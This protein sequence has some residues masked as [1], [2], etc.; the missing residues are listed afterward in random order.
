MMW[1]WALF[2]ILL[3]I[4]AAGGF[5]TVFGMAVVNGAVNL[6]VEFPYISTCGAY[7][8]QSCLFS[9]VMNIGA[10]LVTWVCVIRYQ[11]IRDLGCHSH[12]NTV[13][14]VTGCLSAL[15]ATLVGNFQTIAEI[16]VH[17]A[18]A[19]LSF[20]IG[21][22]YFWLQVGL[23]YQVKPRHGGKWCGPVRIICCLACTASLASMLWLHVSGMRSAAAIC[24]WVAGMVLLLL[25]GLFAVDFRHV[26]GH[27]FHVQRNPVVIQNSTTTL[28]L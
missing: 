4:T 14:L 24:E 19:F 17:L 16:H 20:F 26:D 5:W 28:E 8:P 9:Q 15:G 10:F 18:G 27:Y 2:P 1:A 23:T 11:Q 7:P 21:T 3:M 6:T 12:L 25:F 22:L 13:S